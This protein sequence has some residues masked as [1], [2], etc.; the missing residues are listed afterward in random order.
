MCSLG[1]L[2]LPF[3]GCHVAL[4]CPSTALRG[5]QHQHFHVQGLWPAAVW[6][7]RV[8]GK[9]KPAEPHQVALGREGVCTTPAEGES[10]AKG[11]RR[12]SSLADTSTKSTGMLANKSRIELVAGAP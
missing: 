7:A 6:C 4:A 8:G 12:L 11:L 9:G 10:S 5:A 3:W 1:S 2:D